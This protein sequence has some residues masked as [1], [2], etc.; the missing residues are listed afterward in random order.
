M[1][2]AA[3]D[4]A[5]RVPDAQLASAYD[6]WYEFVKAAW[7]DDHGRDD[8]EIT[9]VALELYPSGTPARPVTRRLSTP[10]GDA[11]VFRPAWFSTYDPEQSE[12]GK[13]SINGP[14][15]EL[16]DF[17]FDYRF[18]PPRAKLVVELPDERMSR[19]IL[20]V[21]DDSSSAVPRARQPETAPEGRA[22]GGRQPTIFIG[23][24]GPNQLW[25]I[26]KDYL[27]E[28]GFQV[29]TF[30]SAPRYGRSA[31]HVVWEM[32]Q[33]ADFALLLH[34]AD[35]ETHFGTVRSRQNVVHETGLFQ[36]RLGFEKAI[37]IREEGVEEF[38]NLAGIQEIRFPRGN[39]EAAH[40]EILRALHDTFPAR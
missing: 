21:I 13:I 8:V 2:R 19:T 25:R 16:F 37:I 38:S 35:D 24:G 29:V 34:T 17:S 5:V 33:Q 15:Y 11:L 30:E 22:I 32:L 20:E 1:P 28:F 23:H 14:R 4:M 6:M 31:A 36:G 12:H 3:V 18:R 39:I 26:L 27:S 7:E 10:S 40:G 9:V